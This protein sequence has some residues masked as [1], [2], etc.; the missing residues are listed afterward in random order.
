MHQITFRFCFYSLTCSNNHLQKIGCG[1]IDITNTSHWI[2]NAW[3]K[4]IHY[5]CSPK[6]MLLI[7]KTDKRTKIKKIEWKQSCS[8]GRDKFG[9]VKMLMR[10]HERMN[11]LTNCVRIPY[12]NDMFITSN[13]LWSSEVKGTMP[14]Y[15][16]YGTAIPVWQFLTNKPL[17]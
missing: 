8:R 5:F 15:V 2:G 7:L 14:L 11:Q 12:P 6:R 13:R 4:N 16:Q 1:M 10:K 17:I 3:N 9:D